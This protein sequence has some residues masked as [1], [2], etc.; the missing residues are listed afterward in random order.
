MT[1]DV[2]P[3]IELKRGEAVRAVAGNRADYRP[4]ATPLCPDGDAL[5]CVGGYLSLYPFTRMYI[6]DL[7]AIEGGAPQEGVLREIG[8]AFPQLEL[9]VDAGFD[10]PKAAADWA[11]LKLG[12]PV[13]GSES[14]KEALPSRRIEGILSLDFRGERFL[15]PPTLLSD[16]ESW[17]AE[18]IVMCLHDVGTGSGPD[19]ARLTRIIQRAGSRRVYAAGGVRHR[20]DLEALARAG[21]TGALIASALHNGAISSDDLAS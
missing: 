6:A 21:I 10:S 13:L 1:F 11:S 16:P 5:T 9:W 3:V 8:A 2:I 7:D 17:P 14:L 15:G 18:I 12:R 4:L 19:I 20:A